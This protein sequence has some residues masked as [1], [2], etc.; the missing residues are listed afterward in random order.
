MYHVVLF[1]VTQ[2]FSYIFELEDLLDK[3]KIA[4]ERDKNEAS[5]E[6]L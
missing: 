5:E 1:Y 3:L 6:T 2:L 4:F